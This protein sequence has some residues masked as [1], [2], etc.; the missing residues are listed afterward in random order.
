MFPIRLIPLERDAVQRLVAEQPGLV[1][2]QIPARTYPGQTEPR[3]TVAPT[4]LL[5]ATSDKPDDEVK[6]LLQL[7]YESTDYLAF[8]SAQ[9][10]RI[11][12]AS[13]TRGIAIPLHPAAVA[14]FGKAATLKP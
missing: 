11:S 3:A 6:A 12:R 14:Y 2:I 5:V 8:G 9:G 10:V 4:A 7:A 1:A 13:G